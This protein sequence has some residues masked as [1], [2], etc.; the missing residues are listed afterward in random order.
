M[1]QLFQK[2]QMLRGCFSRFFTECGEMWLLRMV[3]SKHALLK[4]YMMMGEN[5]RF[6]DFRICILAGESRSD[7]PCG[8]PAGD[9]HPERRDTHK[10]CRY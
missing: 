8:C 6:E 1:L 9:H 5:A 7:T 3:E 2:Y 4:L 10:G